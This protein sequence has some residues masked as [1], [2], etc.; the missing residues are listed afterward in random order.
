MYFQYFPA[1]IH[2]NAA[3]TKVSKSFPRL[4]ES[5]TL[6]NHPNRSFQQ[7]QSL[8][9]I[10]LGATAATA[11]SSSPPSKEPSS[12]GQQEQQQQSS[13]FEFPA[14]ESSSNFQFPAQDAFS[15]TLN[16]GAPMVAAHA[17]SPSSSRSNSSSSSSP[18]S[19][20]V[21]SPQVK[22]KSSSRDHNF[23]WMTG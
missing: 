10:P 3:A 16:N 11:S 8:P 15:S 2:I 13:D 6:G 4:R 20:S 1:Y 21:A 18:S 5:H 7:S 12:S 17:R 22:F 14:Q 23:G 9:Y 19:D